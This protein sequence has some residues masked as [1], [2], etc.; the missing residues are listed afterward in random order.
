MSD[1]S[2]LLEIEKPFQ[3]SVPMK[4]NTLRITTKHYA[5]CSSTKNSKKKVVGWRKQKR[6]R[7]FPT[8][9]L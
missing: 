1:L 9:N 7:N 3:F 8:R 2:F 6:N 5:H 4:S